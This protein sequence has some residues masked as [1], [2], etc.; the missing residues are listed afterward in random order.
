[1][2]LG[3]LIRS[4]KLFLSLHLFLLEHNENKDKYDF[5]LY[6]PSFCPFSS[7]SPPYSHY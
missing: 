1:M 4:H 7:P 3:H 6:I 2:K 5:Q